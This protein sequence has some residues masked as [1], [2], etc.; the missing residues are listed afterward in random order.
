MNK[1]LENERLLIE[2]AERGSEL[3]RIYDKQK[4]R[5]MLW[6]AD[7]AIWPKHSPLLF[8]MVGQSYNKVYRHEGKVYEMQNH[9]FSWTSKFDFIDSEQGLSAVLKDS[10]E[11]LSQYPFH[12][13]LKVTHQLAGN[14]ITVSWQVKNTGDTVMYY[15]IGAHPA[16]RMQPGKKSSDMYLTFPGKSSLSYMLIQAGGSGCALTDTVYEM[17][18]ENSTIRVS[19]HFWDKDAYI[20]DHQNIEVLGLLDEEKA[21]YVTVY[22]KGFPN[23]GVWAK[24][25]APFICLE[26]WYGRCDNH[27][28]EGELKDKTG[29][30]TLAA[31]ETQEFSYIIEIA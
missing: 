4:K 29:V 25:N 7:P 26:P 31:G 18:L 21:P 5:E 16:F 1:T 6:D 17:P 12:F 13:N 9:G 19:E 27:G 20:F 11:S 28:Y 24:P 3:V 2:V 14:K 30:M 10:E 23:V 15:N 22:C 8:P